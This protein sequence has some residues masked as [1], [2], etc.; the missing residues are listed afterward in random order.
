MSQEIPNFRERAENC[1][2]MAAKSRD[3]QVRETFLYIASTWRELAA[4]NELPHPLTNGKASSVKY[5]APTR[6]LGN[7]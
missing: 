4:A 6:H 5:L 2:R 7:G 3:P 1:E